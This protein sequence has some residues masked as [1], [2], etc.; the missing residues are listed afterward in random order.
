LELGVAVKAIFTPE[1]G[2]RGDAD[3]GKMI[4]DQKDP[5]TGIQIVSLY[6]KKRS[7]EAT[8]LEDID[9]VLFDIQDVGV[10]FYTYISTMHEVMKAC[11]DSDIPVMILDRPNPNGHYVDGPVLDLEYQSFVGMHPIPIVYGMTV[12]ELALMIKGESW[13]DTEKTCD[14]TVIPCLNYDHSKIYNPP[15]KPSPN[16]PNLRSILLYPSL[17]LFEGTQVSIGRGT[18]NQFQ[19]IGHPDYTPGS[20]TFI[21]EPKPGATKPKLEGESCYGT[22]LVN[23]QPEQIAQWKK[24]S[25]GYLLSYHNYLKERNS[26]FLPNKYFDRLAGGDQLRKQIE[27]GASESEIRE[28]WASDLESFKSTRSRYLLYPDF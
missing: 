12:G 21:P 6:G 3:A 9:V 25:L 8:D 4:T 18:D 7:P 13:L 28:S 1:H 11:A 27:N 19:V 16:L 2:F 10:R 14:L 17:C 22:S 5:A 20:Y 24:I 26:F 23:L 15:V